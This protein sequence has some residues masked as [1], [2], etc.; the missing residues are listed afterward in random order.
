MC[1]GDVVVI[2]VCRHQVKS[3]TTFGGKAYA[4][5]HVAVRTEVLH[6]VVGT[7]TGP[8]HRTCLFGGQEHITE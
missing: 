1:D 3:D 7:C 8:N 4:N 2:R 5:T 6:G